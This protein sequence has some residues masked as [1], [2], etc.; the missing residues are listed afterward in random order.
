MHVRVPYD[1]ADRPATPHL[2]I[3]A[4]SRNDD[5][6]GDMRARMQHFI[7]GFFAQCR[8]HHLDAELVLV[9][10]N[11]PA[12]RPPLAAAIEWPADFGPARAR[13]VT[14]PHA[15]HALVAPGLDLPLFQMIGKNVGIRRARGRFVLASNVDI[16]FDDAL[17]GYLRDR[18]EPGTMLRVDRYDV[19]SDLPRDV[20]FAQVLA[21]CARRFF[22]VNA[23]FGTFD[24]RAREML[25]V[26]PGFKAQCRAAYLEARVFGP[27]TGARRLLR[28][29]GK[30]AVYRISSQ[31][32]RLSCSPAWLRAAMRR[33]LPLRTLHIRMARRLRRGLSALARTS[34][35]FAPRRWRRGAAARWRLVE[36]GLAMIFPVSDTDQ[37]LR[38]LRRLH[39]NACGDFTLLA[40]QDWFRLQGYPEWPIHSWHLDS[41][42]LYA[43]AANGI[44]EVALGSGYRIYH[45]DHGA[46][47]TPSSG[48]DLFARLDA[49]G[50]RYLTN[51]DLGRWR[52]L[53]ATFPERALV[54]GAD[55]GLAACQLPEREILPA[56][57]DARDRAERAV[58][59]T[60]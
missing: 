59:A 52:Q 16:L 4:V 30:S 47:W 44:A 56:A 57:Q 37:R 31:V 14:V 53:T 2:S 60:P 38:S 42:F 15:I 35:W 50:I 28:Y 6:G 7:D 46:G 24:I 49:K 27:W 54:N 3:V 12:D 41:A 26:G 48:R 55:W 34:R 18:L 36:R 22:H 21:D 39:T 25:A 58:A 17:V 5:H 20:P 10:W 11:P 23:R 40:R 45:I 43:A 8:R 1:P 32:A 9:E 29:A 33:I 19:P 51:Q 13:V